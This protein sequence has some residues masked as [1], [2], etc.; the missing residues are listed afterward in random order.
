MSDAVLIAIA[1]LL[2]ALLTQIISWFINKRKAPVEINKIQAD[3]DLTRSELASKYQ[4]IASKA[5]D[6]TN[7]ID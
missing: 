1:T 3:T 6:E 4:E 7:E 5:V 2:S